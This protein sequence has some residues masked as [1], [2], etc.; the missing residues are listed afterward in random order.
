MERD[1]LHNARCSFCGKSESMV[2]RLIEG[3]DN[4]YICDEC[5]ALCN[6]LI[7]AQDAFKDKTVKDDGM[8]LPKPMEIKA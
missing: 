1:D 3:P 8:T 7:T 6:D 4:V 5:V 2:F